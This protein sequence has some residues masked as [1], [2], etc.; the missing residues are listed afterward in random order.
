MLHPQ[1][2]EL[3]NLH[4]EVTSKHFEFRGEPAPH[5]FCELKILVTSE[6]PGDFI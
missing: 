2:S 3:L 6:M 5:E 1:L 4:R